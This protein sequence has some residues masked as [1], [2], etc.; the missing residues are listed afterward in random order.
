MFARLHH[1]ISSQPDR[2]IP[3]SQGEVT[4]NQALAR[5]IAPMSLLRPRLD[6]AV[7]TGHSGTVDRVFINDMV[8][9]P[10]TEMEVNAVLPAVLE[11][12][13][14]LFIFSPGGPAP[15][16]NSGGSG[17]KGTR[18]LASAPFLLVR[19]GSG[20]SNSAGGNAVNPVNA[21]R[22]HV[23]FTEIVNSRE[24]TRESR[25]EK[26][27]ENVKFYHVNNSRAGGGP[28]PG[29]PA[30]NQPV[31]AR[32]LAPGHLNPARA[33]ELGEPGK[34]GKAE[35]IKIEQTDLDLEQFTHRVY[36]MLEQKIR[37]EKEMR[38]W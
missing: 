24:N 17:N 20:S 34:T 32:A 37:Q 13:R 23:R 38:G 10:G 28:G 14:M 33:G 15:G 6:P 21:V 16:A 22:E 3:E 25:R 27:I 31:D 4:G 8:R 7:I 35:K 19:P 5:A 29:V 36:G 9:L 30:N 12:R 1:F 18:P 26:V 2:D 11:H